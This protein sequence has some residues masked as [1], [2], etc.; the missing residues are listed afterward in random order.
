MDV[1]DIDTIETYDGTK[2]NKHHLKYI[3]IVYCWLGRALII[4]GGFHWCLLEIV[5]SCGSAGSSFH[6]HQDGGNETELES[7]AKVTTSV[8]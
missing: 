1:D 3:A 7:A 8:F 4:S 2:Q 6:N 5:S